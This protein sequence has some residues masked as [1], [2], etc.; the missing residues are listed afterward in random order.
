[1]FHAV[2][3]LALS[4]ALAPGESPLEVR[5]KQVAAIVSSDAKWPDDLF[6]PSFLR[7]VPPAQM[8]AIGAQFFAQCGAVKDVALVSKQSEFHA[9]YD[10]L[11]EKDVVFPMTLGLSPQPPH[12]VIELWFGAPA[13]AVKDLAGIGAELAKLPGTASLAVHRL[14]GKEPDVVFEREADKPL[15][16]GSAFKLW[17]LGALVRDVAD[18]KRAW[19]NVVTLDPARRSL[20]SGF[21]Q[22]WPAAS[23]I[24]LHTLASL[25]ISQS[26][27]TATDTLL[28]ALG[29]E[30]VEATIEPMGCRAA[31][32]NRPLLSTA[33]MF[34]LKLVDGGK[35][36]E[37]F[38]AKDVAARRAYL[39][40]EIAALS[41]ERAD[42]TRFA[43]PIAIDTVEWFASASDLCREMDWLRRATESGPA[44]DARQILSINRGLDV[45]ADLFPYCGFKGGSE[46]GV[47][48]LTFLLQDRSRTWW[49]LS[50]TWND[51]SAPVDD[52]RFMG[53]VTRAI[54]L[55]GSDSV[56]APVTREKPPSGWILRY[57]VESPAGGDREKLASTIADVW[58]ARLSSSDWKSARVEIESAGR[59]AVVL[60]GLDESEIPSIQ[61]VLER[62]SALEFRLVAERD[63]LVAAGVDLDAEMKACHDAAVSAEQKSTRA[64]R[65]PRY[66]G[67]REKGFEWVPNDEPANTIDE[68]G[69]YLKLSDDAGVDASHVV[70]LE[71]TEDS[72]GLPALLFELNAA[73]RRGLAE[74]TTKNINR[75]LAIVL[76]DRIVSA[77]IINSPIVGGTGIIE[78]PGGFSDADLQTLIASIRGGS[79]PVQPSFVSRERMP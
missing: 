30:R 4:L 33:E 38:V 8:K 22:S 25:M 40:G 17:I 14:G 78:K 47:L 79:L 57:G 39:D 62:P 7:Q 15:A 63:E 19:S 60:P 55:V 36:A 29:R 44:A 34:K 28:F 21:L 56:A 5:V 41:L 59:I 24:T 52:A 35:P 69:E 3:G 18:G 6:D 58:K 67:P 64:I 53:L 12:S 76:G 45:P 75:R 74:L 65:P 48:D 70:R 27:N 11:G 13:P 23:P 37:A 46:P 32:R 73:G 20:P 49:A 1:M 51:P 68:R 16:L 66:L 26:D 72:L 42:P 71:R 10:V 61:H 31:A 50:A 43:K 9:K 54:R 2:A 77:P